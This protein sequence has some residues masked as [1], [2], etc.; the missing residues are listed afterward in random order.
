MRKGET[1][2]QTTVTV[3]GSS[4]VA[5][6]DGRVAIL[7]QTKQLGPIAFEVDQHAIDTLRRELVLAET[8]LRQSTGK[9]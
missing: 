8:F 4:T 9:A 3:T 7:L 1:K 6:P 2:D 5:R